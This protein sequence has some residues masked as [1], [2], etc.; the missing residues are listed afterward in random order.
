[1]LGT[2]HPKLLA[3]ASCTRSLSALIGITWRKKWEFGAALTGLDPG[4]RLLEVGAGSG[5][6]LRAA[7]A[8]G[9]RASGLEFNPAAAARLHSEGFEVLEAD[10]AALS[11]RIDP[12][13]DAV[14]A[15]QVL[16]HVPDPRRLLEEMIGALRPGGRLVL[17]VPNAA[18]MRVVDPGRDD[19]LDQPPHHM[20]HWDEG[21]FRAL[22]GLLPVRVRQ[23]CREPLAPYHIGWF[24]SAYSRVL[25]DRLGRTI[26]RVV[27]NRVT[28]PFAAW[29]LAQ[30]LRQLVPGHTLLVMLDYRP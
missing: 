9:V 17:S 16:E 29:L 30:G 13:F 1:M 5:H 25:R 11:R 26:S 21:V 10:L 15:F 14:C 2:A 3:A 4:C 22:E 8:R 18:V 6:F 19:L 20:S 27:L 28:R 24:L 12:P 23:V 7:A